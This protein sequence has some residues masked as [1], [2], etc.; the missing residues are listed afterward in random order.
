MSQKTIRDMKHELRATLLIADP[1]K[2]AEMLV[3]LC[4]L[5]GASE[6]YSATANDLAR[7]MQALCLEFGISDE[8][9]HDAMNESEFLGEVWQEVGDGMKILH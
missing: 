3:R 6:Q 8:E 2:R 4:L 1:S 9:I 5:C 7:V